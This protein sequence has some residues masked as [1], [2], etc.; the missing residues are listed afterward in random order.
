MQVKFGK[1]Y[2]CTQFQNSCHT[3]FW[4]HHTA[5]CYLL[6]STLWHSIY[7]SQSSCQCSCEQ[8][9][10]VTLSPF[11][12]SLNH[13]NYIQLIYHQITLPKSDKHKVK[14]MSG[15]EPPATTL[16]ISCLLVKKRK[17]IL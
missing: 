15:I 9:F 13:H 12:L 14:M 4:A 7:Y 11:T 6:A 3:Y 2:K 17:Y 1:S 16:Y 10:C 8:T 5:V